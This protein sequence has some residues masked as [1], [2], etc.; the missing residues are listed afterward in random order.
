MFCLN[1][2][3]DHVS[4]FKKKKKKKSD[5][6]FAEIIKAQSHEAAD[7]EVRIPQNESPSD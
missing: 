1:L 5:H 4:V 6:F 3:Q 7:S 2:T